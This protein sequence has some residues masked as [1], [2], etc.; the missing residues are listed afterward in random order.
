MN[1]PR[2]PGASPLRVAL[3]LLVALTAAACGGAPT[4]DEPADVAPDEQPHATGEPEATPPAEGG[5]GLLHVYFIDVGQGDSALVVTP[6]GHTVLIDAGPTTAG[7]DVVATLRRLGVQ[8]INL[9]V[10]SHA[11]ADHIGGMEDVLDNFEVLRYGDPG[12]PHE[13]NMYAELL[14]RILASGI[15][16]YALSAGQWLQVDEGVEMQVLA[17]PEGYLSGTRSDVNSNS[18]VLLLTYGDVQIL[19]TGDSEADSERRMA[20]EGLLEDVDVL[21][22]AH[23]GG[24]YS[25][26]DAFLQIVQP[27][28]AVISCGVGNSYGHPDP[29]TVARLEEW[30]PGRV[31]RTDLQGTIV[32]ETDGHQIEVYLDRDGPDTGAAVSLVAQ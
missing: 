21:K 15:D 29:D 10:T 27:E 1:L 6:N 23:H 16:A 12:Y 2:P 8:R 20:R 26:T 4:V 14:E 18:V 3:A 28:I 13:S 32:L 24:A 5:D 9:M 31:Y 22:V 11:H 25:T 30:A 19:F 17:P 7:P